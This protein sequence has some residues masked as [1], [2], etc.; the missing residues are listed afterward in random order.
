M[1][2]RLRRCVRLI[3]QELSSLSLVCLSISQ[4][5]T[6]FPPDLPLPL[7][8]LHQVHLPDHYTRTCIFG[9]SPQ[10]LCTHYFYIVS[11][12]C[13]KYQLS[14][15][16]PSPPTLC[17]SPQ[18][19]QHL[20]CRPSSHLQ[21]YLCQHVRSAW[22]FFAPP[23]HSRAARDWGP[24]LLGTSIMFAGALIFTHR[25]PF[26]TGNP[27][28]LSWLGTGTELSWFAPPMAGLCLGLCVSFN[29]MNLVVGKDTY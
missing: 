20:P 15:A 24:F 27:P 14:S 26:L 28:H 19:F 22:G 23:A 9:H 6:H 21:L 11:P 8:G 17:S 25:M 5:P 12:E 1:V 10:T 16:Q 13:N 29:Y 2:H 3:I 7:L 4:F 18:A